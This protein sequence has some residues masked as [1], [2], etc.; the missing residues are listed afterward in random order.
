MP[1]H[2]NFQSRSADEIDAALVAL[3]AMIRVLGEKVEID[4]DR[5][6]QL[7][8]SAVADHPNLKARAQLWINWMAGYTDA[9][10]EKQ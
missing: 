2:S 8:V 7:M 6:H 3:A 5:A 9:D 1:V 10:G 4:T